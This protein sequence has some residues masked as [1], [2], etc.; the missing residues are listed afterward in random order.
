LTLLIPEEIDCV[1]RIDPKVS[2]P[3]PVRSFLLGFAKAPFAPALVVGI[4]WLV[5]KQITQT[6]A[7]WIVGMYFIIP[8]LVAAATFVGAAI[9]LTLAVFCR[10]GWERFGAIA[11]YT[12]VVAVYLLYY[13]TPVRISSTP[14]ENRV[15]LHH[16]AKDRAGTAAVCHV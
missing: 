10:S 4:I 6:D 9:A 1:A 11:A 14:R 2:M 12:V 3:S 5:A 16:V 8:M 13:G 15:M 7:F